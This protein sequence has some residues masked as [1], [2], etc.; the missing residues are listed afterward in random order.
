[1]GS[2]MGMPSISIY[3]YELFEALRVDN[4]LR[5]GSAGIEALLLR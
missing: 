2:G 5:I 3:S 1:M 4:I